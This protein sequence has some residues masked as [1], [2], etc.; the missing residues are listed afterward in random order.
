MYAKHQYMQESE[1]ESTVVI[2]ILIKLY[3]YIV[4]TERDPKLHEY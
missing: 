2:Y 1:Y 3:N 4:I